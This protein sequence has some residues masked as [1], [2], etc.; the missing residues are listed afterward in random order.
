MP[1][2]GKEDYTSEGI[3]LLETIREHVFMRAEFC[4][5]ASSNNAIFKTG[6][7]AESRWG[8]SIYGKG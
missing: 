2:Y 6:C 1:N 8:I 4:N 3:K 5:T 7:T